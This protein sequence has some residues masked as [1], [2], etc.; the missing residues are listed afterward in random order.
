[1]P[2]TRFML[3]KRMLTQNRFYASSWKSPQTPRRGIS[4]RFKAKLIQLSGTLSSR[5]TIVKRTFQIIDEIIYQVPWVLTHSDL[6]NTN[7]LVDSDSGHL[8]GVVD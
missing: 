4:Q 7:I 5:F 2:P 3:L 6:S 8:T 1:M